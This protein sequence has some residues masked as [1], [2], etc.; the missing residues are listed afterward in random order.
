[1]RTFMLDSKGAYSSRV[2]SQ[3]TLSSLRCAGL[4]PVSMSLPARIGAWPVG[5]TGGS[6]ARGRLVGAP[7]PRKA[8]P[9]PLPSPPPMRA[10]LPPSPPPP[11][12]GRA[13]A[14]LLQLEPTRQTVDDGAHA[15]LAGQARDRV[16][17]AVDEVGACR[18]R[19]QL[20]G[21]AGARRVVR[22]QVDGHV[23]EAL[24]QRAHQLGSGARLEQACRRVCVCV[25][26][27][28]GAG[29]GGGGGAL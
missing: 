9:A 12:R 16:H 14:L 25:C 21:H 7:Q 26:A 29:G 1:V 17:A 27:R 3:K 28:E 22:V 23:G 18:G 10:L 2:C 24:A 8:E 6:G 19:C 11:L 13:A 4:M 5:A 20:R 15:G